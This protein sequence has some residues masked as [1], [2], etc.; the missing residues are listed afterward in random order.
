MENSPGPGIQPIFVPADGEQHP[1]EL[2]ALCP[3]DRD[4]SEKLGAVRSAL[5]QRAHV[6]EPDR[7]HL[8]G[9]VAEVAGRRPDVDLT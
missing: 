3:S 1:R 7:K 5:L 6:G 4:L 2:I 9:I 8:A